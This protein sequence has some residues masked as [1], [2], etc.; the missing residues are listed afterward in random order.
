MNTTDTGKNIC[1]NVSA[2]TPYHFKHWY[3]YR[4]EC[5]A[6]SEMSKPVWP[7]VIAL[8]WQVES[9]RFDSASALISLSKKRSD[10]WKP[11]SDFVPHS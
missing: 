8:G 4:N 6:Q 11:S 2:D 7:S 10:L 9:N 1:C 3:N 5:Q